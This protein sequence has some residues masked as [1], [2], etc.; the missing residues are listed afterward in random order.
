[1]Q[2]LNLPP[3]S[4]KI[5]SS[6]TGR[7]IFD[8]LRKKYVRLTPEEWVRQHFLHYLTR[9]LSYPSSLIR[10][11]QEV[12]YHRLRHRSDIVVYNRW[13]RPLMLVECKAPHIHI[14]HAVWRQ[15]ARYNAHCKARLLVITNGIRHFCWKMDYEA[16]KHTLLQDIP[17]F[18]V[19]DRCLFSDETWCV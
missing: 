2:S 4:Y 18:D 10:L 1:M 5:Q 11:E 9:H 15:L 14:T 19:L 7:Q 3:F 17:C 8:V 6:K 12:R 16:G 13:A